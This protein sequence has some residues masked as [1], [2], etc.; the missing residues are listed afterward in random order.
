[1]TV[2]CKFKLD[3]IT[4]RVTNVARRDP[5]GNIVKDERGYMIYDVGEVWDL[6]M[7]PVYAN[8]D[9]DHE[10]SKFWSATP[11]GSFKVSTVNKAAVESMALGKEYYIDITL[12]G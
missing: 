4:R 7:S 10:N 8:G 1:M 12:A 6:D 11:S 2:R 9:P 5:S 3:S